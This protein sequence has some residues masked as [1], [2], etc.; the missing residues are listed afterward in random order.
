M[1]WYKIEVNKG[2]E[3]TYHYIGGSNDDA[4]AIIKRA[5]NGFFVQLDDLLYMDRGQMKDWSQWDQ[6][7]FPCVYINPKDIIAIMEFKGDPREL[8]GA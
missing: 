1:H 5:Q 6:T 2:T 7:L 8:K 3:G 4:A